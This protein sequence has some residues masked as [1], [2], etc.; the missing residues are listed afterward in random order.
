MSPTSSDIILGL[1]EIVVWKQYEAAMI[2]VT[3]L[4]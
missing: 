3:N 4:N 1:H 2:S